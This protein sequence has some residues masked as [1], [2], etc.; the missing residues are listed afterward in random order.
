MKSSLQSKLAAE[1]DKVRSFKTEKEAVEEILN[2][3]RS[4]ITSLR[5]EV[6]Q[7]KVCLARL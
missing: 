3:E 4:L 6:T 5:T 2:S 1:K 7:L